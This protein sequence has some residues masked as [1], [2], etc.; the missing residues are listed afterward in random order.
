M[1]FV[2]SRRAV[3]VLLAVAAQ[4]LFSEPARASAPDRQT[5]CLRS[6]SLPSSLLL[7]KYTVLINRHLRAARPEGAQILYQ[8]L[9]ATVAPSLP[10]RPTLAVR[11]KLHAPL[12]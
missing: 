5:P 8:P 4:L 9:S 1:T 12:R 11:R 6:V 10:N 3:C 7:A 2:F